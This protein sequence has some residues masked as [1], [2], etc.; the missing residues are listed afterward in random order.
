MEKVNYK[1]LL[2]VPSYVAEVIDSCNYRKDV[3]KRVCSFLKNLMRDSKRQNDDSNIF[4][5]VPRSRNYLYKVLGKNYTKHL[6]P[7]LETGIIEQTSYKAGNITN[8]PECR[9]YRIS[10]F[11]QP[12]KSEGKLEL[13]RVSEEVVE[14][15]LVRRVEEVLSVISVSLFEDALKTLDL[16]A[17]EYDETVEEQEP[18]KYYT[19]FNERLDS[20]NKDIEKMF[21]T[22]LFN[23]RNVNINDFQ[24]NEEILE[25]AFPV[26][27]DGKEE[28]KYFTLKGALSLAKKQNK[29]LI[30]DKRKYFITSE[31]KFIKNKKAEKLI[32][33]LSSIKCLKDQV[34]RANRNLTNNRLDTN[35]TN[36]SGYLKDVLIYDND[37]TEI[38]LCNSQLAISTLI[39]DLDTEDFERY[40]ELSLNCKLYKYLEKNLNLK[41]E[42]F[43]KTTCFEV[44]FSSHRN[45]STRLK[46]FKEL[47]PT[48][49]A[50]INNYKEENGYEQFS[51]SLQKKEAEI[52]ID[53]LYEIISKDYFAFTLHDSFIIKRA[54]EEKVREI[55]KTYF[56]EIGFN[57]MLR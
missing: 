45:R 40:K 31:E 26:Y 29:T 28:V 5:Y 22:S 25:E 13:E 39:I 44:M 51:I 16:V 3:R 50:W 14:D 30:K 11:W 41:S 33:D 1:N 4:N 12:E 36:M 56:N 35:I 24:T 19:V 6:L 57:V 2:F 48:V 17:L 46:K 53:N 27:L 21:Q 8:N 49:M 38:D 10:K 37:L 54:D 18:N 9:N 55:I 47:F 34:Y 42:S 15:E 20:L 43:A 52:F 23:I 7:L 32:S